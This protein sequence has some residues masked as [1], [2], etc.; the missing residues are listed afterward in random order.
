V[1]SSDLSLVVVP[2]IEASTEASLVGS[3]SWQPEAASTREAAIGGRPRDPTF[4]TLLD[5]ES[6]DLRTEDPMLPEAATPR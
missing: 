4:M 1:C 2:S 5:D 3:V 6:L